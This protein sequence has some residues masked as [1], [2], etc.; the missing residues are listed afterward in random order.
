MFKLKTTGLG[1]R[2][3]RKNKYNGA[4]RSTHKERNKLGFKNS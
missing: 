4:K 1:S 2:K 3:T